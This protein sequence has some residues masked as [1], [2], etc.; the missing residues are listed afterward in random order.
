MNAAEL[1]EKVLRA[2]TKQTYPSELTE[3]IVVDNGSSDDSVD[4]AKSFGVKVFTQAL[5]KSPYAARNLGFDYATGSIIALTDAN[6]IPDK[7][8]LEEGVRAIEKNNADLAGGQISFKL[9]KNATAAELYDALT[10]NNNRVF[11]NEQNGSAAGNLFFKIEVLRDIGKFPD[12]FRSGMDMWWTAKAVN[13]GYRI[14]FA[15]KAV[16]YCHPRKLKSILKKSWR[17]GV[18]HPV[19]FQQQGKSWFYI[20]DQ[21][22]RTFAPPKLSQLRQKLNRIDQTVSLSTIFTVAWLNKISMGLGR[23]RGLPHLRKTIKIPSN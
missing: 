3:I 17:V 7:K 10:Y 22:F 9:E 2:L 11:V 13:G 6:K 8:W 21:T 23:I 18:L 16:V 5:K 19:I 1:L 15:E 4:I 14:I 12:I 20:L